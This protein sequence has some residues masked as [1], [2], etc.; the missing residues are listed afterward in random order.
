MGVK[1][2]LKQLPCGD[3][4]DQRVRFSTL[5]IL[6]GTTRRLID[7]DTVRLRPLAQGGV[8]PCRAKF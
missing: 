1:G 5:E 7:I 8:R 4:E 2:L 6:Y 3:M